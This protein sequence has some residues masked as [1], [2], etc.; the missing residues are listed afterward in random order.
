MKMHT[1]K[2]A[3][4]AHMKKR[5]GNRLMLPAT[6]LEDFHHHLLIVG[7]IYSFKYFA[8]L[9]SAQFTHQLIVVL[10]TEE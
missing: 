6:H 3:I 1:E 9:P 2:G 4:K 8:V 10:I 5:L 7:H